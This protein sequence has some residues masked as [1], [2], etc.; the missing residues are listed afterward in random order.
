M[1]HPSEYTDEEFHDILM[2]SG[3]MMSI[4]QL[5]E[6]CTE[7]IRRNDIWLRKMSEKIEN[8]M[9]KNEEASSY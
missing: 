3:T 6:F 8:P 9:P 7:Q 1:K 4:E 2:N 5:Q